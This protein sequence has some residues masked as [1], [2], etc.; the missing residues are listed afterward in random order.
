MLVL[1]Y[2]IA[3]ILELTMFLL[4]IGIAGYIVKSIKEVQNRQQPWCFWQN[5]IAEIGVPFLFLLLTTAML[6][7]PVAAF[8]EGGKQ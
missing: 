5:M 3:G 6:L 8:L 4:W 7:I 1:E 2:A